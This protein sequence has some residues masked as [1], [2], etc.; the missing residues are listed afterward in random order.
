MIRSVGLAA[1][2]AG[3]FAAQ[4]G[5]GTLGENFSSFFVLGDSNS[6]FGNLADAGPP[7]PYFSGQFS[8]GPVWADVLDE[9]FGGRHPD[10]GVLNTWNYAFGG[11]RST[12]STDVPDLPTQLLV[13][14]ADLDP[15]VPDPLDDTPEAGDRPLVG[16]W[17]GANDVRAAAEGYLAD[18]GAIDP[19]LNAAE[20]GAAAEAAFD[21]AL[22]IVEEAAATQ[23]EAFSILGEQPGF[24]DFL[25]FTTYSGIPDPDAARTPAFDLTLA[26]N[27]ALLD[28][29]AG[30]S[31]SDDT[32]YVVDV[33]S[34][35]VDLAVN[36]GAVLGFENVSEPCLT[37][38][39]GAPAVCE[40]P[41]SYLIWDDVGHLTGAAHATLASIVEDEILSA[42]P[43]PIPL[44]AGFPLLLAGIFGLGV[45]GR[46]GR[47]KPPVQ[48]R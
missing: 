23:I 44:P 38:V 41:D 10:D 37:F 16:L 14:L 11:A 5:A 22:A 28:G 17:F 9:Q 35:G 3:V 43:A 18:L 34:I 7:P 12:E 33:F 40:N 29:I 30:L 1:L 39:D 48:Q 36:G 8:N 42:Q 20:Q 15:D 47:R 19:V 6:D 24:D 31:G 2:V 25:T 26:F 46:R 32:F 45:L 27:A 13:F 21:D 4:A